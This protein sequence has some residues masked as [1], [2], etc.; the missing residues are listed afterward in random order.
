LRNLSK[1]KQ[2]VGRKAK[3]KFRNMKSPVRDLQW[4][5]FGSA[6]LRAAGWVYA[7]GLMFTLAITSLLSLAALPSLENDR[8]RGD[9]RVL[10]SLEN[11]ERVLDAESATGSLTNRF[12]RAERDM[13]A[14]ER[15]KI[16]AAP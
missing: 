3:D 11:E 16:I 5:K 12:E 7:G 13:I 14:D 10:Q 1:K 15:Q 8:Q 2:L 9:V 4:G 6:R